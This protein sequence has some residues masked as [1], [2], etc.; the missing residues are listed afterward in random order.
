MI[1]GGFVK[2]IDSMGSDLDIVNSARISFDVLHS[3]IEK[4]DGG[5]IKYLM[6]NRHGT[7]FESVEFHFHIKAPFPVVHEWQRHRIA[8]YNEIS[9]RYVQLKNETYVPENGAIRQQTGKPGHYKFEQIGDENIRFHVKQAMEDQYTL[10]YETYEF[11]LDL[12][13]AKELS[14]NILPLGLFTEFRYKTNARS[15]M[16]FL[17]LRNTSDAMYEIRVYAEEIE[18]IFQQILPITAKAF[19][20]NERIAP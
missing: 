2:L 13:V 3:K 15:L 14:R 8:S 20:L 9:G 7:P 1:P 10:A 17:S 18:K 11:L 6:K 19:I 5:L 16:N 12:G 4:G